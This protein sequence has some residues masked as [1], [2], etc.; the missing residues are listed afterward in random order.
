MIQLRAPSSGETREFIPR[1]ALTVHYGDSL[2]VECTSVVHS[3]LRCI[4]GLNECTREHPLWVRTPLKMAV[5]YR[6]RFQIQPLTL[7]LLNIIVFIFY[8]AETFL[9]VIVLFWFQKIGVI[10]LLSNQ[11]FLV[12]NAFPVP[13][14]GPLCHFLSPVVFVVSLYLILFSLLASCI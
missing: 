4:V 9:K 8:T 1:A 14:P 13:C 2:E 6:G 3:F 5:P 11:L 10:A 7:I 12:V